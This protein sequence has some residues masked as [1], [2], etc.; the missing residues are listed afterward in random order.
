M[1]ARN[2]DPEGE[3]IFA[4]MARV[5]VRFGGR[6]QIVHAPVMKDKHCQVPEKEGV[7][8]FDVVRAFQWEV[9][10]SAPSLTLRPPGTAA[11][12]KPLAIVPL[13]MN[14]IG[15]YLRIKVRNLSEEV[16]LMP[17]S[18]F[19]QAGTRLQRQWDFNSG[20]KADMEV[21][22]FGNVRTMRLRG[23]DVVELGKGL[24]DA[25]VSVALMGDPKDPEKSA[26]ADSGLGQCVLNRYV[27]CVDPKAQ[28]VRIMARVADERGV[29]LHASTDP[30]T[31]P[32]RGE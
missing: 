21:T 12:G 18:S 4:G 9:D 15:Y 32:L 29:P 6:E 31:Q 1:L 11:A 5:K 16:A 7:L 30:A 27:Y 2:V 13:R 25:N 26:D 19:L 22:R 17:G 10:P 3:P 20:Q 23:V 8:G 28:Q 24:K 14:D